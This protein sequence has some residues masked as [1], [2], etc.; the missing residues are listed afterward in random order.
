MRATAEA[1]PLARPDLGGVPLRMV[2]VTAANVLMLGTA[3]V[4]WVYKPWGRLLRRRA[5]W[6]V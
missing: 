2:A 1:T 4:P 3:T 5:T 6:S